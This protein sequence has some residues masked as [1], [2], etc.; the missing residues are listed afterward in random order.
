MI[1]GT[2]GSTNRQAFDKP[3]VTIG[4]INGN[5]IILPGGAVSKRHARCV[6]RDGKYIIVD[7]K[8]TN[9]TYVNGRKM[10]APLVI[11][12]DDKIYIGNYT[13]TFGAP[14]EADFDDFDDQ[15]TVEADPTEL[16]LLSAIAQRDDASR[17]VYADWLEE[18]GEAVRAEFLRVQQALV[19]TSPD[20]ASFQA[21]SE[22][23]RA[24]A[25]AIDVA[26][27]YKVARPAIER[28]VAF[29]FECPKDWGSLATTER[30]NVRFCGACSKQ[31]FYCS[32]VDEARRHA[33]RGECVAVDVANLR[34][35]RDLEPRRMMMGMVAPPPRMPIQ[36]IQPPI[37][38][39]DLPTVPPPPPRSPRR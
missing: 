27:R 34:H 14:D 28:C 21:S 23:L 6:Y 3:E 8:S 16:R 38:Q 9:G 25:P 15:V 20:D 26:W 36:P 1:K 37:Q 7:L 32:T 11:R 17:M 33:D 10:T 24:L 12:G 35:S 29:D 13:L 4:R 39:V 2:D 19:T 5:D 30:S 18:H 22:R 31:V